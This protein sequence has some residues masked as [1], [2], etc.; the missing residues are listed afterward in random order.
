MFSVLGRYE[1]G[2]ILYYAVSDGL[3]GIDALTHTELRLL[4]LTGLQVSGVTLNGR[5]IAVVAEDITEQLRSPQE[6]DEGYDF[7]DDYED[8]DDDEEYEDVS[9]D[10]GVEYVEDDEDD[11]E[12]YEDVTSDDDYEFNWGESDEE[13][14]NEVTKLYNMLTPEQ[15]ALLKRYYMWYSQRIFS[16]AQKDPNLGL[17]N[18]KYIADKKRKLAEL[19]GN[20][21]WRYAGMVD[22][23]STVYGYT[24]S[25]E[26]PLRYMHIVCAIDGASDLDTTFFGEDFTVDVEELLDNVKNIRFGIKCVGDF[27]ELSSDCIKAL[28]HTQNEVVKDLKLLYNDYSLGVT[29]EKLD[30][31]NFLDEIALKVGAMDMQKKAVVEGYKP[32][33]APVMYL[34]YKQ[35]RELNMLPPKGLV[36][37]IRSCLMGWTDGMSYFNHKWY[38]Y[39]R[40]PQRSF[41][42]RV[43]PLFQL[44]HL[45]FTVTDNDSIFLETG[46]RSRDYGRAF[47]FSLYLAFAYRIC[48]IYAYN[49]DTSKDEGGSSK[50]IRDLMYFYNKTST[51]V[52]FG[53]LPLTVRSIQAQYMVW[54]IL[55][56][57]SDTSLISL[58]HTSPSDKLGV[59]ESYI[60][61]YGNSRFDDLYKTLRGILSGIGRA[62]M[63]YR[64][65][66]LIDTPLWA[67]DKAT[68]DPMDLFTKTKAFFDEFTSMIPQFKQFCVDYKTK[69]HQEE[70]DK[71]AREH[72]EL[73]KPY[74][75][76]IET[77]RGTKAELCDYLCLKHKLGELVD[78]SVDS[79]NTS[80]LVDYIDGITKRIDDD[81]LTQLFLYTDKKFFTIEADKGVSTRKE[82]LDYLLANKSKIPASDFTHK[83]LNTLSKSGTE[84]S[85]NQA[86]YLAKT[87]KSL[88]G[89]DFTESDD[90]KVALSDSKDIETAIGYVLDNNLTDKLSVGSADSIKIKSILETIRKYGEISDRQMKYAKEAL[91][92]YVEATS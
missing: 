76:L 24:C 34:A 12:E 4:S 16:N 70:L 5:E 2:G 22:T 63:D 35:F 83:I 62:L 56:Q 26:H 88:T 74:T 6:T 28:Q 20:E 57:V 8:E 27:F 44:P 14:Y 50:R 32:I 23:G 65:K 79:I 67:V 51:S 53:H 30:S 77:A 84:P 49:A 42:D 82:L 36:Q 66:S 52:L 21:Q 37:N 31:F 54:Y 75:K 41:Y 59:I 73:L 9:S 10:S 17:K 61:A 92:Y 25:L 87:Y 15:V 71:L 69:K 3:G 55:R 46:Y 1:S 91:R 86:Y 39:L 58:L 64:H 33:I 78:T 43:L 38:G 81:T 13:E 18:K 45:D 72:E 19:R 11:E 48:G 80:R 7:D 85:R 89:I 47:K 29:Q 60:D 68:I 40:Y 90:S